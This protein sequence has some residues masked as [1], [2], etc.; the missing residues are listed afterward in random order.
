MALGEVARD[1][2][3]FSLFDPD[4]PRLYQPSFSMPA[5]ARRTFGA[6]VPGSTRAI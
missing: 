6:R 5:I 2:A 1:M 4:L 3:A